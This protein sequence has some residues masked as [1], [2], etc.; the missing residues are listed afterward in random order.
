M[1]K[2]LFSLTQNSPTKRKLDQ[3]QPDN[4]LFGPSVQKSFTLKNPVPSHNTNNH[5]IQ[6]EHPD[7]SPYVYSAIFNSQNCKSAR[8][9]GNHRIIQ[10]QSQ[11]SNLLLYNYE[12]P[13]TNKSA[14]RQIFQ[15]RRQPPRTATFRMRERTAMQSKVPDERMMQQIKK[16]IDSFRPKTVQWDESLNDGMFGLMAEPRQETPEV[17]KDQIQNKHQKSKQKQGPVGPSVTILSGKII[18]DN[19]PININE[20]PVAAP[21]I[22]TKAFCQDYVGVPNSLSFMM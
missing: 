2:N 20:K 19:E 10:T 6:F 16:E 22:S 4:H 8:R 13:Q 9:N 3:N 12:R 14:D 5:S 18:V 7:A 11:P 1:K 21:L 15:S 17:E